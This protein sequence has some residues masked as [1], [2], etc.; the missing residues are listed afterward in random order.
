LVEIARSSDRISTLSLRTKMSPPV[1]SSAVESLAQTG[2][3]LAA[4]AAASARTDFSM[5]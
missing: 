3:A 2:E 5:R 4:N 1:A